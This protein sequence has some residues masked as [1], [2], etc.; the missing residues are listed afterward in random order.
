MQISYT[1]EFVWYETEKRLRPVHRK[2]T[3]TMHTIVSKG[4][5]L[6]AVRKEIDEDVREQY[7]KING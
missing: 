7:D 5:D 2:T 4:T 6:E 1:V 3:G